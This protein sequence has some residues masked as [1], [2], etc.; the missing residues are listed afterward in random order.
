MNNP[1]TP[2]QSSTNALL[3]SGSLLI[4]LALIIL[5]SSSWA[6]VAP[7]YHIL[8]AIIPVVALYFIGFKTKTLPQQQKISQATLLTASA[9]FPIALGIIIYQSGLYTFVDATLVFLVSLISLIW[10]LILEFVF[11]LPW[12]SAGTIIAGTALVY[13]FASL[14]DARAWG[15]SLLSLLLA[16]FFLSLGLNYQRHDDTSINAWLYNHTGLLLGLFGALTFPLNLLNAYAELQKPIYYTLLYVIVSLLLFAIAITYSKEWQRSKAP[17][18]LLMRQVTET[19]SALTLTVPAFI[20]MFASSDTTDTLMAVV[21]GVASLVISNYIRVRLFRTLGLITLGFAILRILFFAVTQV[22]AFWPV[23]LLLL[24]FLL[25]GLAYLAHQ[26]EYKNIL[27]KILGSP[28]DSLFG[29]G[30]NPEPP[31]PTPP[32]PPTSTAS[33][34]NGTVHMSGSSTQPTSWGKIVWYI[35]LGGLVIIFIQSIVNP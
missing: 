9:I 33:A 24:G 4:V 26:I 32:A 3:A 18:S 29:L 6:N 35:L 14:I 2:N 17:F 31:M 16:Y 28:S 19:F 27:Q 5:V 1:E 21:C 34:M 30:V 8:I 11:L 23:L 25:I 13:S 20:I 22:A 10:F 12:H 15:Y 7:A